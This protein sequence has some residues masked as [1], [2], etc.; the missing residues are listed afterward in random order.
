MAY[1]GRVL[2]KKE[3]G[4]SDTLNCGFVI[5]IYLDRLEV[6]LVDELIDVGFNS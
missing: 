4:L 6:S 2:L 5:R 1:V 3:E